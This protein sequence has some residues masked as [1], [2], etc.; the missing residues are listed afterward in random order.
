[1]TVYR[2]PGLQYWKTGLEDSQDKA[3]NE[4]ATKRTSSRHSQQGACTIADRVIRMHDARVQSIELNAHPRDIDSSLLERMSV[5]R[6]TYWKDMR[7]SFSSSKDR[8]FLLA[9]T[10]WRRVLSLLWV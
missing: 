8:W 9:P 5:N 6:K 10:P 2:S 1:M 4:G 7:K 3:R